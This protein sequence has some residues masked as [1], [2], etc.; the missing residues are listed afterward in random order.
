MNLNSIKTKFENKQIDKWTYIDEMYS[1]HEI[2]FDYCD[3]IKNT[4]ISK[5]EI[6]DGDLIWF[7]K[8]SHKP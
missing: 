5:I 7:D 8:K 6:I 1:Q 3:F 4:N 2:L